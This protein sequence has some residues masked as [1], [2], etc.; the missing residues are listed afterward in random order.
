MS[1]NFAKTD[2]FSAKV[3]SLMKQEE[4]APY[5]EFVHL[6]GDVFKPN[7]CAFCKTKPRRFYREDIWTLG[8]EPGATEDAWQDEIKI[9]A[10]E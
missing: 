3:D 1:Y 8:N 5:E 4:R 6:Y 7:P 9:S 10:T 2:V